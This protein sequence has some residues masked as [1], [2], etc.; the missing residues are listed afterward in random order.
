MFNVLSTIFSN[1]IKARHRVLYNSSNQINRN[2]EHIGGWHISTSSFLNVSSIRREILRMLQFSCALSM[3][4]SLTANTT[5]SWV[6]IVTGFLFHTGTMDNT[7]IAS[8][9][10]TI[11]FKPAE[12]ISSFHNP[13]KVQG[14][15]Y[16]YNA[17]QQLITIASIIALYE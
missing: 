2:Y 15:Q 12:V 11:F 3:I 14:G 17:H 5:N 1:Q 13:L 9:K 16:C 7:P 8:K 4:A 6:S 10:F